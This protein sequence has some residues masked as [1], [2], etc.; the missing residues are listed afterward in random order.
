MDWGRNQVRS[1]R[2]RKTRRAFGD[3][4]LKFNLCCCSRQLVPLLVIGSISVLLLLKTRKVARGITAILSPKVRNQSSVARYSTDDRDKR[5]QYVICMKTSLPTTTRILHVLSPGQT[6]L[7][8]RSRKWTQ[9]ELPSQVSSQ[10]Q[11]SRK[12]KKKKKK[13]LRQTI[14]YF[15]G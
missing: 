14:L 9:V 4:V 7:V 15:N 6:A 10:V 8:K 1:P 3:Q 11:A 13:K 2:K 12:K 5:N